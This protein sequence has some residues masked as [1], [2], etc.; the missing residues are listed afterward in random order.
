MS[1]FCL[2]C[3]HYAKGFTLLGK[4]VVT[5][6][7]NGLNLGTQHL[8]S[9]DW[10]IATLTTVGN[11]NILLVNSIKR[12]YNIFVMLRDVFLYSYTINVI[13]SSIGQIQ[14]QK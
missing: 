2:A 11:D 13:D 7:I 6:D 5:Y 4:L 3:G 14:K 10:T 1:I 12:F 8:A 9:F